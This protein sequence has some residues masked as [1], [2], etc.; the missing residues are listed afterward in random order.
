MVDDTANIEQAARD[1]VAGASFDNNIICIDEKTVIAVRSVA[2]E[3]IRAMG[4]HGAH[5]LKEHELKKVERMIF[6]SMGPPGKPGIINRSWIGKN[7]GRHRRRRPGS[8]SMATPG[9]S[10]PRCRSSTTWCGPSR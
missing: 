3:L 8:R 9:C 7:A 1:I 4:R 2:D 5:I 6:D 10:S